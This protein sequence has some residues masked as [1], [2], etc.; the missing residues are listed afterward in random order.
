MVIARVNGMHLSAQ[1]AHLMRR[2]AAFHPEC[3]AARVRSHQRRA[4]CVLTVTCAGAL[5]AAMGLWWAEITLLPALL[6]AGLGAYAA[7]LEATDI[8]IE[9]T[10]PQAEAI[11]PIERR[12]V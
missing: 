1:G 7:H 9:V 2:R 6:L 10:E 12:M 11:A 3:I 5:A 8:R 4:R